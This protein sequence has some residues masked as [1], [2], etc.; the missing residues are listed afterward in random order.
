MYFDEL[1]CLQFLTFLLFKV[2]D[3]RFQLREATNSETI[4]ML[5][6]KH[7]MYIIYIYTVSKDGSCN[8]PTLSK[9]PCTHTLLTTLYPHSLNHPVP[10]PLQCCT[11]VIKDVSV[12]CRGNFNIYRICLVWE[13]YHWIVQVTCEFLN[14]SGK[15]LRMWTEH[16]GYLGKKM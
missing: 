1:F 14:F 2:V 6:M 4:T 5:I 9:P 12:K 8:L 13:V 10:I 3:F 15:F 7:I 16:I 11:K